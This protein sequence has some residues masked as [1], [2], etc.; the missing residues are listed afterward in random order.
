[1]EVSQRRYYRMAQEFLD[2][3]AKK[4]GF[5]S[6]RGLN[7]LTIIALS[8]TFKSMSVKEEE[9]L[10]IRQPNTAIRQYDLLIT[11]KNIYINSGKDP[12]VS[13]IRNFSMSGRPQMLKALAFLKEEMAVRVC[14]FVEKITTEETPAGQAGDLT[15]FYKKFKEFVNVKTGEGKDFELDVEYL[16]ILKD[17]GDRAEEICENLAGDTAFMSSM[18]RLLM[19]EKAENFTPQ[20]I[21]LSDIIKIFNLVALGEKLTAIPV[22]QKFVL[23]Y[24]FERLQGK[25]MVEALTIDRINKLV[26]SEKFNENIGLIAEASFFDVGEE[27]KKEF[28]LPSILRRIDSVEFDGAGSFLYRVASLMAKGDSAISDEEKKVLSTILDKVRNPK[29]KLEGV[30]R[31]EV[32][33]GDTLEAVMQ[34]LNGLIGMAEIK[35]KIH[36]LINFLKVQKLRQE[37]G[38]KTTNTSLHAVFMGPPGTGKT[39]IARLIGRI[40][41]HLGYLEKGH[42][43]ETDRAGMV[44]GFVGQTALKVEEVVKSALGG[45]LFIDEAYSLANSSNQNDFG[46]EAVE[47]LLKRMED[48]R[49]DLAVVVAGY[50]DEMEEFIMSNPGI[51]SRF[52]RYYRFEHYPAVELLE[53]FKVF[54]GKSDF[55]LTKDAEEKLLEIFDRLYEKRHPSFGNARVAR[56]LFEQIIERQATRIVSITPVTKELLMTIEEPDVPPIMKTVEDILVFK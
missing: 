8:N 27:Y 22:R 46:K 52:S 16:Q 48:H 33:E 26:S 44:A 11:N 15:E 42:L 43:V 3:A 7:P 1:M 36:E 56:N 23:A 34:E 2:E 37:Q 51:Q 17:E 41:R 40:Y 32:N 45:V 55:Q 31:S 30:I 4:G 47:I 29:Q 21:L 12:K 25:D 39:T 14:E 49:K 38:L 28:L 50:P 19:K 35:K 6:G 20:L 5:I 9:I 54:A 18:N 10:L 13:D 24:L 53:I